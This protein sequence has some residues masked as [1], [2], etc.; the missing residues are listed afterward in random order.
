MR[1]AIV[2]PGAQIFG[3]FDEGLAMGSHLESQHVTAVGVAAHTAPG[4]GLDVH[5]HGIAT[6]V[7][8]AARGAPPA[9]AL[10]ELQA[11]GLVVGERLG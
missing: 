11:L 7:K 4:T 2:K 3:G 6:S 8:V 1:L 5:A 10:A 9:L